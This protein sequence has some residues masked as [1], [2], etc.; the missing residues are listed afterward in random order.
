MKQIVKYNITLLLLS[1]ILT[2]GDWGHY[3]FIE[4]TEYPVPTQFTTKDKWDK[5]VLLAKSRGILR[6]IPERNYMNMEFPTQDA[7]EGARLERYLRI[8]IAHPSM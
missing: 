6:R 5:G 3:A 2:G 8:S 4:S 1:I 7:Y